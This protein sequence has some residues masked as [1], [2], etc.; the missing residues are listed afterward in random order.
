MGT[1]ARTPSDSSEPERRARNGTKR[2]RRELR[3]LLTQYDPESPQQWFYPKK[4]AEASLLSL[5]EMIDAAPMHRF[6]VPNKQ[7]LPWNGLYVIF[8]LNPDHP[9]LGQAASGVQPIYEGC[10]RSF[11]TMDGDVE[12]QFRLHDRL[13]VHQK[14]IEESEDLDIEDFGYKFIL[15]EDLWILSMEDYLIR[16]APGFF[17]GTGF[18]I[19]DKKRRKKAM[20]DLW[21]KRAWNGEKVPKSK[22]FLEAEAQA[23][24]KF[25]ELLGDSARVALRVEQA[26][27]LAADFS[28]MVRRNRRQSLR[29]VRE[30]GKPTRTARRQARSGTQVHG[31]STKRTAG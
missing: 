5:F 20:Y 30:R 13:S 8:Y 7:D 3:K 28:A 19:K 11:K 27:G 4:S 16:T 22:A 24:A 17:N 12:E 14:S 1:T 6:P 15:M 2:S 29:A 23:A 31:T 18:G 25:E 9:R 26:G 10:A 21:F